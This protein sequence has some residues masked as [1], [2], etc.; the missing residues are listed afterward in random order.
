M[1]SS[2]F[3]IIEPNAMLSRATIAFQQL[4]EYTKAADGLWTA[5]F[6][7]PIHVRISDPS[8]ERCRR[9]ALD[10]LDSKLEAWLT[11]PQ[12]GVGNPPGLARRVLAKTRRPKTAATKKRAIAKSR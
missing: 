12:V 4:T 7:G 9:L 2:S 8:L 1:P 10:D 6:S 3:P 11:A 5:E